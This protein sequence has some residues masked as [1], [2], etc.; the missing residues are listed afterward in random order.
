[1]EEYSFTIPADPARIEPLQ[2]EVQLV[3]QARGVRLRHIHAVLLALGEWLENVI[4]HARLD[5]RRHQIEVGL[6]V[7]HDEVR[8]LIVDEGAEFDPCTA[9]EQTRR[10]RPDDPPDRSRGLHL[11]RHLMDELAYRREA[12]RNR[13]SMSKRVL[14]RN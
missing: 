10:D 3:L 8:L 6:A 5:A 11:I 1:M 2:E 7:L 13:F 9:G 4:Q 14:A 12:G